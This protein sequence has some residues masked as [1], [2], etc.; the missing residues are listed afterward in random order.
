MDAARQWSIPR[1]AGFLSEM[2]VAH[3]APPGTGIGAAFWPSLF[4]LYKKK[5]LKHPVN[6]AV[7]PY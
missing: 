3:A 6:R 2:D 5:R 1:H 4:F 7:K